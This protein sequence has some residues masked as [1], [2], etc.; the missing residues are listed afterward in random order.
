M[1]LDLI[2]IVLVRTFHPGNIGAAARSMKT[3]GLSDLCLVK[4]REF[5]SAQADKMAAGAAELL[6]HV[7]VVETLPAAIADCTVVIA[8]TARARSYDLPE[9]FPEQAARMLVDGA[10]RSPVALVFGPERMGLHNRDMQHARYRLTIPAN[11]EYSSLNMA[12]AVQ[13]LS[14]EIFKAAQI[15]GANRTDPVR[16]LP[17]S[18]DIERLYS[19]LEEVLHEIQFLR[20]HQGETLQRIRKLINRAEPNVLETN[21]LRG[22]L[23]AVQKSLSRD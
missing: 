16:E 13:I 17:T 23:S 22:I 2:R 12:A 8:S 5:P 15:T 9:L 11:P 1:S 4:P 19:H 14:Y 7:K 20:V 10:A 18:A 6:N 3:M 21:I